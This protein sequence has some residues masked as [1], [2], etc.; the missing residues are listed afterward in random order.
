MIAETRIKIV[1]GLLLA[2]CV[3]ATIASVPVAFASL[4]SFDAPG[5]MSTLSAWG[6]FLTMLICPLLAVGAGVV[7]LTNLAI[8]SAKM[9]VVALAL[10][11]FPATAMLFLAWSMFGAA[12]SQPLCPAESFHVP[13]QHQD[14]RCL[15]ARR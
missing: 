13:P 2:V 15:S 6:M 10:I 1:S 14:P 7:A 8:G 9:L 11:A 12:S 4:F 5:S 3:P